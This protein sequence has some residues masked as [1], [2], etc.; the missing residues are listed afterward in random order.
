MT[1]TLDKICYL[2]DLLEQKQ[3]KRLVFNHMVINSL[4]EDLNRHAKKKAENYSYEI[5]FTSQDL[6][7]LAEDIRNTFKRWEY[8]TNPERIIKKFKGKT[9]I[10][11]SEVNK[12]V[13]EYLSYRTA[14][15]MPLT[16][17]LGICEG[18]AFVLYFMEIDADDETA[19]LTERLI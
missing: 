3:D 15:I 11:L 18:F 7:E 1:K 10:D 12:T 13:G 6:R 14:N 4:I 17:I 19:K 9:D 2:R 8:Q 5:E 16:R